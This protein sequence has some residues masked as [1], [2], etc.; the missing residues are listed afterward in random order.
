[1]PGTHIDQSWEIPGGF[2]LLKIET[3]QPMLALD[4]VMLK[5]VIST[6]NDF[7]RSMQPDEEETTVDGMEPVPAG[8]DLG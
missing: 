3:R 2:V 6:L 5:D 4:F 7:A 8:S 1:M